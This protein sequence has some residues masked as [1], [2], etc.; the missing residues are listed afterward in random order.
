V[1]ASLLNL[2]RRAASGQVAFDTKPASE[3]AMIQTMI[4]TFEAGLDF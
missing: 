4:Q 2:V 1:T 3:S